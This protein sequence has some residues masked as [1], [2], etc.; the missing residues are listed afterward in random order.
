MANL[1]FVISGEGE[2]AEEHQWEACGV[3]L[4]F[5][6]Q[7]G[8]QR[9]GLKYVKLLKIK[10]KYII[11]IIEIEQVDQNEPEDDLEEVITTTSC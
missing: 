1:Y 6:D 3:H 7:S 4:W 5:W 2:L 10:F 8:N 9:S 11:E